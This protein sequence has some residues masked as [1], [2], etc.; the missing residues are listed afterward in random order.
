MTLAREQGNPVKLG[1]GTV[2]VVEFWATWCV[3]TAMLK[4]PICS[5][6][7][8]KYAGIARRA[9]S[10]CCCVVG[11]ARRGVT[12][13]VYSPALPVHLSVGQSVRARPG[14]LHVHAAVSGMSYEL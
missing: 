8:H 12:L 11:R 2:T 5:N 6:A 7:A 4:C 14:A 13:A 10:P 9:W 3:R 1:G